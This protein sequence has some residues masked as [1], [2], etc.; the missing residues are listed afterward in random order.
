MGSK[1]A[2]IAPASVIN[3]ERT[4]AKMGRSMKKCENFILEASSSNRSFRFADCLPG[5][6]RASIP[7]GCRSLACPRLERLIP[8]AGDLLRNRSCYLLVDRL[9]SRDAD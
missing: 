4:D 6:A 3:T 1:K 8:G 2:V 9:S 7:A 5:F